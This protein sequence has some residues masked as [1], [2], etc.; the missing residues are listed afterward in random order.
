MDCDDV[1]LA[2]ANRV[3]RTLTGVEETGFHAH[4]AECDTCRTL[5]VDVDTESD[6]RWIARLPDDAFDDPHVLVLPVV[7]PIVFDIDQEIASGG[8][9]RITKAL[10]RRLGR[11]VAIKEVLEPR[12]RARF[13]REAMITARLQHPAI[14]PI[15]EAGTWP[16]GS[17]FY[18]MRLVS[19]GTLAAAIH[20]TTTMAQRLA[21]LPHVIAVTEALAYAHSHRIIHRDLK[22]G[23]VLVGEFGETVVIDWGLAKELDRVID[24]R[25]DDGTSTERG[26]TSAGSVLGTPGFM[27]P[28]QAGGE[29]IDERADVYALG[30]ILYNLLA[31]A[32]PYWDTHANES[33]DLMIEI[34]RLRPPTPIAVLAP[35]APADLVAIVEQA[36]TRSRAGRYA[37]ARELAEELRRFEAGKLI[38]RVYTLRELAWRWIRR[39]RTAVGVGVVAVVALAVVGIIAFVNIDRSRDAERD[40]R[41]VAEIAR[42][43]AERRVAA[44]LAE[45]GRTELVNGQPLRALAYLSDALTRGQDNV[46]V[47]FLLARATRG[48]DLVEAT[49]PAR[50]ATALRFRGD[51]ALLVVTPVEAAIW[52]GGTKTRTLALTRHDGVYLDPDA[53]FVATTANPHT[54]AMWDVDAGRQ[55]WQL[56]DA[57]FADATVTFDHGGTR[58]ATRSED[59]QVTQ[60]RA[61]ATG[62]LLASLAMPAPI[63][64][65]AFSP[66]DTLVVTLDTN[67][68]IKAWD[69][70][71][72]VMRAALQSAS[73]PFLVEFVDSAHIV[74]AG[75]KPFAEIWKLGDRHPEHLLANDGGIAALAVGDELIV[76]GD[77]RG[78]VR[79]W[80]STGALLGVVNE[81]DDAVDYLAVDRTSIVGAGGGGPVYVWD[82][83]TLAVHATLDPHRDEGDPIARAGTRLATATDRDTQIWSIP[84][85]DGRA[86]ES[87]VV[88][89]RG[90]VWITA[91]S[92]ATTVHRIGS[93]NAVAVLPALDGNPLFLQVSRDGRRAI[94]VRQ[95]DVLVLDLSGDQQRVMRTVGNA[96]LSADGRFVADVWGHVRVLDAVTGAKVFE[97]RYPKDRGPTEGDLAPDGS[98]LAVLVE[99]DVEVWNTVTRSRTAVFELGEPTD[100]LR[101]D[102]TGRRLVA[103]GI[104]RAHVIDL[105][106]SRHVTL[107]TGTQTQQA[108]WN[109]DGRRILIQSTMHDVR[110]YEVEHA[111]LLARADHV[112]SDAFALAGDGERFATGAKD[113]TVSM[114]SATGRLLDRLHPFRD[115]IDELG[116]SGDDG[117]LV[118]STSGSA[119][120]LD[121]AIDRRTP[122]E[123]A[124]IARTYS[125]WQVDDGALVPR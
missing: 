38:A 75:A 18:T 82:A 49:V 61:R 5:L 104:T 50:R 79:L 30:A 6:W 105:A 124:A 63:V 116:F 16:N 11:D 86:I 32:P 87:R 108:A 22:P 20:K 12:L 41:T 88:F 68:A 107:E 60:L 121:V 101:F 119:L 27:S 70:R 81:L 93:P 21:L 112:S 23:N 39:H 98:L 114:W 80:S 55:L 62:A 106:T 118:V 76:T 100:G 115:P 13:E 97:T 111:T 78:S 26:L 29:P 103:F 8:M 84:A 15:Y 73:D 17:A 3:Q 10:D 33:S 31:G 102:P 40:A 71:S 89:V 122:A 83:K 44:L 85:R 28:E 1:M 92:T 52:T 77:D 46:A 74:T 95:D 64:V 59:R 123:I 47:R 37:T 57:A 36:M 42:D 24:A 35:E 91:S 48:L 96:R 66:D 53:R 109:A 58:I 113:G 4:L 90:D 67:G 56:D 45:H 72:F 7:D 25:D 51:G 14:V 2:I 43:R 94:Q 19:G 69:T 110:L 120:V 54:L 117:H 125:P 34:G 9:G 65:C 99:N